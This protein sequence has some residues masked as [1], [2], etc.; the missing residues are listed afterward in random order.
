MKWLDDLKKRQVHDDWVESFDWGTRCLICGNATTNKRK[1]FWG[2]MNIF[3]AWFYQVLA[4]SLLI[5]AI[6]LMLIYLL[7]GKDL[8]NDDGIYDFFWIL[9]YAY[10]GMLFLYLRQV[11]FGKEAKT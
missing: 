1:Q 5:S 6:V 4:V 8:I 7:H 11:T 3:G 10:A 9:L 2:M